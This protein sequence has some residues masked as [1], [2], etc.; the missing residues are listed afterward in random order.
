[1]TDVGILA[2]FEDS[3]EAH[4]GVVHRSDFED[5][6]ARHFQNGGAPDDSSWYALRNVVY[7]TGC[8]TLL[9]KQ[10]GLTWSE[11][12]RRSWPYF[13]NALSVHVDLLYTQTGLSA[14]RALAAMVRISPLH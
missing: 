10:K 3:F 14:V 1:V 6:L 8:R 13:E 2:Y 12:H 5:R 9:A 4:Y 11:V 7:A